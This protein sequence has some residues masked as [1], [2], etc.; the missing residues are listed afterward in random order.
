MIKSAEDNAATA[1]TKATTMITMPQ[2]M[3]DLHQCYSD[4][5]SVYTNNAQASSSAIVESTG[6][7]LATNAQRQDNT[8][9][10]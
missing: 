4:D 3:N 7:N 9:S 1:K 5:K 8:A 10:C 6:R 2:W